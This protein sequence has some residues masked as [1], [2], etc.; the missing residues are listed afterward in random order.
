VTRADLLDAQAL[1]KKRTAVDRQGSARMQRIGIAISTRLLPLFCLLIVF[2]SGAYGLGPNRLIS[3]YGHTVW[4]SKEDNVPPANAITQTTDGYIWIGR[5]SN[6]W[7]FDGVQFVPWRPP[8]GEMFSGFVNYLLG[9]RDGS[10]WIGTR[11]GLYRLK[12]GNLSSYTKPGDQFG[13]ST[14][15]ED[16]AG[17]IWLTRYL[18]P[19]GEGGLC[20][21]EG[22]GLHCYGKQDGF[23]ASYGLGMTED[24]AG[25][26]WVAGG[27]RLYRW[28]PGTEAS[29]YLDG[30]GQPSVVDVA[31]DGSGDLWGVMNAPGPQAGV[32]HFH[33]GAWSDYIA[34]G[35]NSSKLA[36]DGFFVDRAG[37]LWIEGTNDGLYRI[38]KG[39]VDHFSRSN[40]LSGHEVRCMWEDR[41]G[42]LWVIT[43]GGIDLFRNTPVITYSVD[44]GLAEN[45][46]PS[47]LALRDGT[48][49]VGNLDGQ[50][51]GGEERID[52]SHAGPARRFST[53]PVFPGRVGAMLQDHS[54]AIIVEANSYPVIVE[55]GRTERILGQDGEPFKDD[56]ITAFLEDQDHTIYAVDSNKLLRIR[57]R[58]VVEEISLP[59]RSPVG[60]LLALNPGGGI[61]VVEPQGGVMLYKDGIVRAFPIPDSKEA[62]TIH[63][64]IADPDDPLLL[65][66]SIG[67]FRWSGKQWQVVDEAKGLPCKGLTGAIKDRHGS[68]WL[69][70]S[71]GL[72]EAEASDLERWRENPGSALSF[73]VFDARD[74]DETGFS[75][76]LQPLMSLAP[77]GKVWFVN[78]HKVEMI[79][80]DQVYRNPLPPPVYV[81]QLIADN[82]HYAASGRPRIPPN[83]R[84]LEIDYAALSYSVP[85][86]VQFR[87]FLEGH[88][89]GW[90]DPGTR[91]Q[92]FYTDL[93][94]GTYRFHVIACNNSG[95]WNRAG[96]VAEFVVEPTFYQTVWFRA[97][98]A[99]LA[100]GLLWWLYVLRLRQATANAQERVLAQVQ[101]R[102]R[103]A[104]ELHDTLLQGFQGI[105]LQVQGIAKK[106]TGEDPLRTMMDEVLDRA[107]ETLSEA[108]QRVRK[109]RQRAT[110]VNELPTFIEKYGREL[111]QTH[112]ANFVLTIIGAQRPLESTV[113][114][115]ACDIATESLRNAFQH[116]SASS[117]EAEI[118]Y[119]AAFLCIRVRD[120]GVGIEESLLANGRPGHWGLGGMQ[121]RA[122]T[123]RAELKICSRAGAGTEVE[124]VIP[125]ALAFP[126]KNGVAG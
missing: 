29:R 93:S 39:T 32:Q 98:L 118:V 45:T 104:R 23:P 21:V 87:Y 107:D 58:R 11:A 83:P 43:D 97:G 59:K 16:H 46:A 117:V 108:R 54:G 27:N 102:E 34:P 95:V 19:R 81:E 33:N 116:A 40:G 80:P 89:K 1:S 36:A 61:W 57:D 121:E 35:F 123:I 3:Q 24:S 4:R 73:T 10:L 75:F 120:D 72:L 94:P 64:V 15:L 112:S 109:L 25:N 111:A 7:R 60:S 37:A 38:W 8:K 77:D 68:L 44:E 48:I 41:E 62:V 28:K 5:Q 105:A 114:D 31:V 56:L 69:A 22:H 82:Q 50:G 96:A 52:I 110:D 113:Q 12:D 126:E 103:I 2:S 18:A 101:E 78:G 51:W 100:A 74:G 76:H 92:V 84:N 99:I 71:C 90:Q 70:A 119:D 9:A 55:H 67:L 79:D 17:N 14:I 20:E 65:G 125:A 85:Q 122:R 47:V 91:R 86:R 115:E 66:T 30:P 88:D 26:L 53:G 63:S 49:W 124:L 106:L 42:N 6:L 13:I